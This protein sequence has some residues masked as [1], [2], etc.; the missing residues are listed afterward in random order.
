[1]KQLFLLYFLKILKRFFS[2]KFFEISFQVKASWELL[3]EEKLTEALKFK[4]R[5][6]KFFGEGKYQLALSK[7][8]FKIILKNFKIILKK[9]ASLC[10]GHL[11][12][13]INIF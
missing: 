3:D 10:Y 9:W 11:I 1:M 2:D 5:G 6:T 7:V 4:E 13:A 8:I 12:L